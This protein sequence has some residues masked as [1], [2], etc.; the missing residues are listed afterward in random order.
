MIFMSPLTNHS[1]FSFQKQWG[2]GGITAHLPEFYV[3][4]HGEAQ[5][6]RADTTL[7]LQREPGVLGGC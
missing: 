5:C 6:R 2:G 3:D 4:I 7:H 1:E